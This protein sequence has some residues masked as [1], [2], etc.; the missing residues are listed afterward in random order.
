VDVVF[1]TPRGALIGLVVAIPLAATWMRERRAAKARQLLALAPPAR[2]S[3]LPPSVA[4]VVA[5]GLLATA[6]AQPTVRSVRESPVRTDAEVYVTFDTTGSM[7]ASG[8]RGSATRLERA[9]DFAMQLRASLPEV[10]VGVASITNRPLPHLF[11]TADADAFAGTAHALGVN[12]PPP[13]VDVFVYTTSLA[14]LERFAFENFFAPDSVKRLVV[15]LS[16]GESGAFAPRI[17][18][19]TLA[20]GSVELVVV[21]FWDETERIW[22]EDGRIDPEYAPAPAAHAPLV[23]LAS[24]T[25]G[26]RIYEETELGAVASAVRGYVGAGPV[27]PRTTTGPATPLALYLVLAAALPLALLL[28]RG[29][30]PRPAGGLWTAL[31]TVCSARARDRRGR[32][33]SADEER[34]LGSRRAHPSGDHRRAPRAGPASQGGGARA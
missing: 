24:L 33:W 9:V 4:L 12:R 8:G 3:H 23:D 10:K 14:S 1:L 20:E 21:R 32:S 30:A 29:L 19:R 31:H 13:G 34:E 28:A 5:F 7:A 11:P 16:D 25:T 17:L 22:L 6:A 26:G 18:T 27:T 15:L 2:R